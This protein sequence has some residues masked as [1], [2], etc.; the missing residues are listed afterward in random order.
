[1]KNLLD[2]TQ[3]KICHLTAGHPPFDDR[4]FHK[5][6]KTLAQAGYDVAIIAQHDKQEVVDGVR[7]I[8]LPTPKSRFERMTKI[9][10]K[11]FNVALREK[12]DVYH[13]H[14]PELIPY[15]LILKLLGKKVIY[16]VHEDYPKQVLYKEWVGNIY[17]R[18]LVAFV[19]RVAERTGAFFFDGIIVATPDIGKGF[20]PDKTI[21]LRNMPVLE[22]IHK[23]AP[24]DEKTDKYVVIYAGGLSKARGIKET[25]QSMQFVGNKAE[26][27]LLGKWMDDEFRKECE[28]LEEFKYVR[29][30]GFVPL[31]EVYRYMKKAAV[32]VSVL[33]PIEN[34]ITSL[35]VKA[36][37]YMTC[38]LPMVMSDFPYWQ[39]IFGECALF[40]D[41]YNPKDI[42]DKILYLLDNPDKAKQLAYGGR[43]LVEEECNWEAESRK[44]IDLYKG[45]LGGNKTS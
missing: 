22:L 19:T 33:Y 16:D 44:L 8:P 41:P 20:S 7:I 18:K 4:I 24:A 10:W 39:K 45:L 14:D 3:F 13:F 35:P 2:K 6:T 12:A 21:I 30:L 28:A 27:W 38:S 26:L 31:N 1:M 43:R 5:E 17:I 37:E 25:I 34:Y 36:Y 23:A 11:L 42:A 9:G 40:A 32:G 29:Y 15:G